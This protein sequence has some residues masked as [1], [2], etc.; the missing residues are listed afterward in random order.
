M[1]T[2]E[3]G[4]GLREHRGRGDADVGLARVFWVVRLRRGLRGVCAWW[5]NRRDL[6]VGDTRR[7]YRSAMK[8]GGEALDPIVCCGDS[9]EEWVCL[10]RESVACAYWERE[11]SSAHL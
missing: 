4:G 2:V 5:A 7:R 1:V 8:I 10:S 6:R 9:S 11:N 3:W